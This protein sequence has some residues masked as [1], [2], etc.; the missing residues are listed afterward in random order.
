MTNLHA[1]WPR[2]QALARIGVAGCSLLCPGM[3]P[4][5]PRGAV[6]LPIA[7]D[8]PAQIN[9]AQRRG[10]PLV[11]LVSLDGCPYCELVRRSYLLPLAAEQSISVV[12][13]DVRSAQPVRHPANGAASTHDELTRQWQARMTPTVL[14]LGPGGAE[15]AP[16]LVGVPSADFYGAYLEERLLQARRSL[17]NMPSR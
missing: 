13:V 3:G 1:A 8:L 16:R 11:V 10:Q 4:A 17:Q 6:N 7:A 15:V 2:R 5:Q 9:A 14:F 12:Q